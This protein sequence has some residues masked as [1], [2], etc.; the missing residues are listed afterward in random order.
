MDYLLDRIPHFPLA[1]VMGVFLSNAGRYVLCAALVS[2]WV[3]FKGRWNQRRTTRHLLIEMSQSVVGCSIFTLEYFLTRV[4]ESSGLTHF[5]SKIDDYGIL[6]FFLTVVILLLGVDMN[7]YLVHRGLHRIGLKRSTHLWHHRAD[8]PSPWAL[9]SF[10]APDIFLLS[11]FAFSVPFWMPVHPLALQAATLIFFVHGT[12]GHSGVEI[13]PKGWT[14]LP[15]LRN[16]STV[17][18]HSIHHETGNCHYGLFFTYL[19]RWL[20]TEHPA[21][22]KIFEERSGS[23]RVEALSSTPASPQ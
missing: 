7:F 2:A 9:L 20:G 21:Y 14:Q 4:L 1:A 16:I 3:Y 13:Y 22:G 6:Y 8:P 5:Y 15:I 23:S 11:L 18:H 17:T 10:S 19:D 12:V